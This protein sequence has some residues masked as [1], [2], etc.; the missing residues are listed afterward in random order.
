MDNISARRL[1]RSKSQDSRRMRASSRWEGRFIC[2]LHFTRFGSRDGSRDR[3]LGRELRNEIRNIDLEPKET[4][5]KMSRARSTHRMRDV[6]QRQPHLYQE[7][8]RSSD[9]SNW[10]GNTNP[11]HFPERAPS[12]TS[13]FLGKKLLRAIL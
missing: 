13:E 1:P 12:E 4:R 2:F 6:K 10:E 8:D 9:D 5:S 11:H 7:E 3:A